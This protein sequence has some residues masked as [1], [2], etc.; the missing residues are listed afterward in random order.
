MPYTAKRH[1]MMLLEN[2]IM[3]TE[4]KYQ[5]IYVAFLTYLWQSAPVN[6]RKFKNIW[7]RKGPEAISNSGESIIT[8][9]NKTLN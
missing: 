4:I 9:N 8:V 1:T 5:E 3:Y 7:Q 6:G 2:N